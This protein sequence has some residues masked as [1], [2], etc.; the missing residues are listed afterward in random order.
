MSLFWRKSSPS[1]LNVLVRVPMTPSTVTRKS[2]SGPSPAA[3]R[4]TT[5]EAE[6][7]DVLGQLVKPTRFDGVTSREPKLIPDTV[8]LYPAV[9][10][11]LSSAVKLT[12]GAAQIEFHLK[13]GTEG[14]PARQAI[15]GC[16]S[17]RRVS[18][19]KNSR[20]TPIH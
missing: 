7:H 6:A 1:K 2:F 16:M 14:K 3:S 8:T 9:A 18:A 20:E 12:E 19:P 15:C 5:E 13:P 10:T 17:L 11:P 4:Q